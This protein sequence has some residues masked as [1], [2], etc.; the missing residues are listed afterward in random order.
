MKTQQCLKYC[1][2]SKFPVIKKQQQTWKEDLH[3]SRN[4]TFFI[5]ILKGKV[6][7]KAVIRLCLNKSDHPFWRGK[8]VFAKR[9]RDSQFVK[10]QWI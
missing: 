2:M 7:C 10:K 4:N 3:V 1:G 9:Q 8:A 6:L 5:V